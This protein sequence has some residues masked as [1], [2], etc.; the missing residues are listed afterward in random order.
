MIRP[1]PNTRI[2]G[3][4]ILTLVSVLAVLANPGTAEASPGDITTVAGG[5]GF[6]GDGGPATL[7]RLHGPEGV[8]AGPTG[9]IYIADTWN[10]RIRKVDPT[11]TISTVAG[12]GERGF[13]GD[14]GPATEASLN[15]PEG[16]FVGPEGAIFVADTGNNQVRKVDPTGVITVVAGRGRVGFAGDGG[17]AAS[18]RD[19][20]PPMAS[21]AHSPVGTNLA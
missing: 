19:T 15:R 5:R 7:A 10:N 2:C 13:G 11:G 20:M 21:R 6:A 17:P 4:R 1:R 18:T 8:C 14:G 12:N 3:S 16:L 9:D